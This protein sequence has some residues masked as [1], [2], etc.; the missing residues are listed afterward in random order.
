M[1]RKIKDF[2]VYTFTDYDY[3]WN[4][5]GERETYR[6]IR[7][8]RIFFALSGLWLVGACIYLV[9]YAFA[10]YSLVEIMKFAGSFITVIA[11]TIVI[12]GIVDGGY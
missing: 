6:T 12:A 5:A 8:A 4:K 7:W 10:N 9:C 2:L 1:Y 11:I 3:R